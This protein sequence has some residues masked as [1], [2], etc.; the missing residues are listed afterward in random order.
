MI[1]I[2]V[3]AKAQ[4]LL[5]IHGFRELP[6]KSEGVSCS[7]CGKP[8]GDAKFCPHCGQPRGGSALGP[9]ALGLAL[10]LSV[11]LGGFAVI[12]LRQSR[13]SGRLP[14][15]PA[16]STPAPAPSPIA[17][18]AT[19]T[20]TSPSPSLTDIPGIESISDQEAIEGLARLEAPFT[21]DQVAAQVEGDWGFV[22]VARRDPKT[23]D[24]A[25]SL[26]GL[27]RRQQGRWSLQKWGDPSE[28]QGYRSQ[29]KPKEDQAF[30][31]WRAGHF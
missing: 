12:G 11:A 4:G 16:Q 21:P 26:S 19:P 7:G 27:Y 20:P 14:P 29:M 5:S 13:S 1:N 18:A 28:W 15:T 3:W 31:R 23:G 30:E 25:E 24:W 17:E 9:A 6:V 2:I 8:C 10:L 22:D